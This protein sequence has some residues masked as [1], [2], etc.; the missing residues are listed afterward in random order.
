MNLIGPL[1]L[2]KGRS[3]GAGQGFVVRQRMDFLEPIVICQECHQGWNEPYLPKTEGGIPF[4]PKCRSVDF[5]P[6]PANFPRPSKLSPMADPIEDVPEL[7]L[8][9]PEEEEE[10]DTDSEDSCELEILTRPDDP[11]EFLP[12]NPEFNEPKPDIPD[13]T[14]QPCAKVQRIWQPE[15]P[16]W[17]EDISDDEKEGKTEAENLIE[18]ANTMLDLYGHPDAEE[19]ESRERERAKAI[20]RVNSMYEKA[21]KEKPYYRLMPGVVV[22]KTRS[23]RVVKRPMAVMFGIE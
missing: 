8:D 14:E 3:Q 11:E 16:C 10:S 20:T 5:E 15:D 18:A 12:S 7:I 22:G 19:R 4:C 2:L 17:G 21:H 23:G 13:D 9:E 6:Y 1:K